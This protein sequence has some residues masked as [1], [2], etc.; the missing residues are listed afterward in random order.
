MFPKFT[1]LEYLGRGTTVKASFIVTKKPPGLDEEHYAPVTIC[2]ESAYSRVLEHLKMIVAD[3]EMTRAHMK[4]IMETTKRVNDTFL[5]YR[6]RREAG[7]AV[8]DKTYIEAR[9]EPPPRIR[10]PRAP[11]EPTNAPMRE[12]K[13]GGNAT[14]PRSGPRVKHVKKV[15]TSLASKENK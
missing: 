14:Q 5:A 3:P 6:L 15:R 13:S 8:P 10:E 7:E 4:T 11:R 1:I 12:P 9:I 2:L